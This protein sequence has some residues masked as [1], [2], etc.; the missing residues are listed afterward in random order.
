MPSGGIGRKGSVRKPNHL[1]AASVAGLPM[2]PRTPE[3][4]K[5]APYLRLPLMAVARR[6]SSVARARAI[7]RLACLR[8]PPPATYCT[9][10]KIT[11]PAA[12]TG[13]GRWLA[14]RSWRD[15]GNALL[16]IW[17]S[18]LPADTRPIRCALTRYPVDNGSPDSS[19]VC[20]TRQ[21]RSGDLRA[22]TMVVAPAGATAD[23]A[24]C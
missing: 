16:L 21:H 13:T 12:G 8:N 19:D 9:L 3:R 4:W 14:G 18:C 11:L 6:Q 20:R 10:K 24:G 7:G 15:A 1:L 17:R 5:S 22:E 2:Q 23:D